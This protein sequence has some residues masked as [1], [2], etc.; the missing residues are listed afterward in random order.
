[1]KVPTKEASMLGEPELDRGRTESNRSAITPCPP[2]P[3]IVAGQ[4]SVYGLAEE[5]R[6]SHRTTLAI[7]VA[8]I[9]IG[10]L[11][12]FLVTGGRG[13]KNGSGPEDSLPG[14]AEVARVTAPNAPVDRVHPGPPAGT[15]HAAGHGKKGPKGSHNGG[16]NHS[17]SDDPP[18]GGGTDGG[19]GSGGEE[20]TPLATVD[21][22][23][24]GTVTV[25]EPEV[26][27]LPDADGSVPDLPDLPAP[28]VDLP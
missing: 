11:G 24:V 10:L 15:D 18:P 14:A 6:P 16:K 20:S 3:F 2:V 13:A 8:G 9:A 19:G 12:A 7:A 26:P 1:L 17:A 21:L 25:D 5:R 27:P 28:D 23:V 22:P 4:S